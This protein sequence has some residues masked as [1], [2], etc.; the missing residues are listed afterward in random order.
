MQLVGARPELEHYV[1]CFHA[2][3]EVLLQDR[4]GIT[5]LAS[6]TFRNEDKMFQAGPPEEQ[7]VAR[8]LPRKLKLSLKYSQ[9]RTF[10]SDLEI[11]LRTI[12]GLK[13][14]AAN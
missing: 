10:L 9:A 2:E 14:P 7:Y 3:Y 6:L 4:P 11:L 5:D 12:F 8:I 13:S 1:K